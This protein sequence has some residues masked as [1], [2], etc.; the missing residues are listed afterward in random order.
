M[1]TANI[2]HRVFRITDGSIS[3]TAFTIDFDARQ[4]L[5][6]AK[7]VV[8]DPMVAT[9]LQIF[10]SGSWTPL[11]V[12]FVGA[13]PGDA[14]VTVLGANRQLTDPKLPVTPSLDG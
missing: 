7:H 14:D 11:S 5:I 2:I 13:A 12:D 10:S 6:T 8:P 1:I 9:R 4:Y 3:G